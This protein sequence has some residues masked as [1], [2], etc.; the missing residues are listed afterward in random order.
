MKVSF[1]IFLI[2]LLAP[3][4]VHLTAVLLAPMLVF[5]ALFS[6]PLS[7]IVAGIAVPS[8]HAFLVRRPRRVSQQFALAAPMGAVLGV[9]V[10]G[11]LFW[12]A[13][14][15]G[16][17]A[18]GYAAFGVLNSVLCWLLYNWGPLNVSGEAYFVR[19]STPR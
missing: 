14:W 9:V 15:S 8:L 11:V 18:A 7:V 4:L 10:Y 2:V 6:Y 5:T 3:A 17:M 16:S 13:E 12:A 19:I 1:R